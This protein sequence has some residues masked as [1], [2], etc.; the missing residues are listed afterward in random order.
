MKQVKSITLTI[1]IWNYN[2]IV[3]VPST[4]PTFDVWANTVGKG[5]YKQTSSDLTEESI[6]LLRMFHFIAVS[7]II[8]FTYERMSTND[9]MKLRLIGSKKHKMDFML[10]E[11]VNNQIFNVST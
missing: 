8:T 2:H 7:L 1:L 4:R 6:S 10:N 11:A 3:K 5:R 9:R